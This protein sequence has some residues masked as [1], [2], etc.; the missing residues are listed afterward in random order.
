MALSHYHVIERPSGSYRG[1]VKVIG[2]YT[3]KHGRPGYGA[4]QSAG[5]IAKIYADKLRETAPSRIGPGYFMVGRS[6][7]RTVV[8]Q[9]RGCYDLDVC[10]GQEA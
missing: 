7:T 4:Q 6:E 3:S 2:T 10:N 9:V 5:R 8:I 1:D